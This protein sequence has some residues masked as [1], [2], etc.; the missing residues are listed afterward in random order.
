MKRKL[1]LLVC[2]VVVLAMVFTFASCNGK[3]NDGDHTHTFSAEWSTNDTAHW[4]EATCGCEGVKSNYSNHVD[5]DNDG[6]CDICDKCDHNI[7][8]DWSSDATH[9][10]NAATCSCPEKDYKA[11]LA[12]HVDADNDS[13]CD[14]CK[15]CFHTYSDEWT[16]DGANHWHE[17][18]CDCDEIYTKDKAAHV[19]E[20]MDG[21][22]DVCG[23]QVCT[24]VDEDENGICDKCTAITDGIKGTFNK[25]DVTAV[26]KMNSAFAKYYQNLVE[27]DFEINANMSVKYYDNYAVYTN[28]DGETFY[29]SLYG[30]SDA[31]FVV[32]VVTY[33]EGEDAI[34]EIGRDTNV[35]EYPVGTTTEIN[36]V[37][38][39]VI[40]T[41]Y[42]AFILGLYN[43][44]GKVGL[45]TTYNAETETV[46]FSYAYADTYDD[47]GR[48]VTDIYLVSVDFVLDKATNGIK[49]ATV[50]IDK[51]AQAD[52]TIDTEANTYAVVENATKIT[53]I[54][55]EIEQT[56]GEVFDSTEEPNPY[57]A[58]GNVVTDDFTVVTKDEDG[59]VTATYGEEDTIVI[60]VGQSIILYFDAETE[61]V[62]KFSDVITSNDDNFMLDCFADTYDEKKPIYISSYTAGDYTC[63]ITVEGYV[64]NLNVKVEYE[65]TTDLE[66][67]VENA[68]GDLTSADSAEAL[69]GTSTII[70][71]IVEYGQNPNTT[72]TVVEGDASKITLEAD[73][74]KWVV[75]ASEAGTYVIELT[76]VDNSELKDRVTITFVD[77]PSMMDL[78][79]GTYKGTTVANR[80]N[81]TTVFT[82]VDETTGTV[83]I[84][85]QG[86]YYVK[87]EDGE[88]T[89]VEVDEE[90]T[91]TYTYDAET[92]ELALTK[93]AGDDLTVL[94]SIIIEDYKVVVNAKNDLP[95]TLTKQVE[96][97]DDDD[98]P[99]VGGEATTSPFDVTTTD[100]YLSN[101]EDWDKFTF[102][103]GAAGNYTFIVPHE[104]DGG[105]YFNAVGLALASGSTPLIDYQ[106]MQASYST[107]IY[108][109]EG[110]N[111]VLAFCGSTK[112]TFSIE[113]TYE[114]AE[115]PEEPTV[116]PGLA[117]V[118]TAVNSWGTSFSVTITDTT[119]TFQPPMSQVIE[120]TYAV[121][122]GTVTIYIDGEAVT[123]PMAAYAEIDTENDVFVA[124][125]YNGYDYELTKQAS[126]GGDDGDDEGGESTSIEGTYTATDAWGGTIDVIIDATTVTFGFYNPRLGGYVTDVYEYTIADGVMTLTRDGEAVSAMMAV[127]T[128]TDGVPTAATYN[129]TSYTLTK[130][131]AT[132]GDEE[133]PTGN[134]LVIGENEVPV[135]GDNAQM[136]EVTFTATE[137]GE[138]TFT[139]GEGVVIEHTQGYTLEYESVSFT[140]EAGQ[141]ITL[142]V[143]NMY[144]TAG[145]GIVTVAFEGNA[146]DETSNALVIGD[147][148]IDFTAD[149]VAA[150]AKEY[151]FNAPVNGQYTFASNDVGARV[152]E[153]GMMLGMGSVH[154]EAG[155]TYTVVVFAMGEGTYTLNITAV[156]DQIG[157]DDG[158]DEEPGTEANPIVWDEIPESVTINSDTIN[159]IYYTFT[160]TQN[161]TLTITYPTA[162]SWADLYAW[163]ND[164]WNGQ[165]SQSSSMKE[166]AVFT[167][168]SDK[169]YRIGIGTFNNAG[170]FT[171][172]IS[173]TEGEVGGGDEPE[174]NVLVIG[175]N[176]VTITEADAEQGGLM[177]TF[178][179]FYAGLYEFASNDV[180]ARV[181]DGE[182]MIGNG[183]VTLEANKTYNVFVGAVEAGTYSLEIIYTEE[184][185][186]E[187]GDEPTE[188][189]MDN[190]IVWDEVP[191]EV[192]I[193]SDTM[194]YTYFKFTATES[195]AL[196]ITFPAGESYAAL[197]AIIDGEIDENSQSSYMKTTVQFAVEEGVTYVL[198][199]STAW[200]TGEFTL[201]I[202]V[203][204]LSADGSRDYPYTGEFDT[205]YTVSFP[206]GYTG[207]YYTFTVTENGY[208]TVSSTYEGTPWLQIGT[209]ADDLTSNLI[210]EDPE[211]YES[212][213][214]SSVTIYALAGQTVYVAIGDYDFEEG[215]V[216][217][218]V[219][220]E[221]FESDPIDSFVGTWTGE[222]IVW[223][224]P[225]PFS[226]TINA[227]GTGTVTYTDWGEEIVTNIT[228]ILVDGTSVTIKA[229]DAYENVTTYSFTYDS[230]AGTLVDATNEVTISK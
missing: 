111:V 162:D 15:Y 19:D 57:P 69:L 6:K 139:A 113:F 112:G 55:Y 106:G 22:C 116:E 62:V 81:I 227:D 94:N 168:E 59:N 95:C 72:Y 223:G 93:T 161:G 38:A 124:F 143:N 39:N 216:P 8:A 31:L 43:L 24:H 53:E 110:E 141:T 171:L 224:T 29:C 60:K 88:Y 126:T 200:E 169:T 34:T 2:V 79:T 97:D 118:Y 167:I 122:N 109:N 58:E 105:Y 215:N 136:T 49:T 190:P 23:Y 16:S 148:T 182:T 84:T 221:A 37:G 71:A 21:L 74:A 187:G 32:K 198:G 64:L 217:F 180:G 178:T 67:G 78:L 115:A 108:L 127:I 213:Y 157:G 147:N 196:I 48:E 13:K 206:G 120:W 151:T 226:M 191:S 33:G 202:S 219:T 211:T 107:T 132:G 130:N 65:E 186:E 140:L 89:P 199:L 61:K 5:A 163:E 76:S 52:V 220:F 51:Y 68:V 203:G 129:G 149:D 102:V 179:T 183:M 159:K 70:G 96:D 119:I 188:G 63:T 100:N 135:T 207:I 189:T 150:G 45:V 153:N 133:E 90:G 7:A 123:N 175:E 101:I 134:E 166:V 4:H 229:E 50:K 73:G 9:H 176:T 160:A 225:N 40:V 11:N 75:T 155:K 99:V 172:P 35:A 56:F 194:N 46:S 177:F 131:G 44:E 205:D 98:E 83:V 230:E 222:Q 87:D 42:E 12:A 218:K 80:F 114:A 28:K 173:F 86:S 20:V 201:P 47:A 137:A 41:N 104:E 158:D 164:Q 197:Y 18:N 145:T 142:S 66:V 165:N 214:S 26:E 25:L 82:A 128:L 14:V 156:E 212:I 146:G 185:G 125:G 17:S 228:F 36:E 10:W 152:F 192:T 91:F 77:A 92:G 85:I 208:V 184:S 103:A 195:G 209:V 117:G 181:F 193:N 154:L 1:T 138:Y 210:G 121:D 144:Y 3:N 54:V 170:E 174:G 30:E 27:Y 204:E